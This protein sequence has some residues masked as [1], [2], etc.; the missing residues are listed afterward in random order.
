[1]NTDITTTILKIYDYLG[2]VA[3]A[4]YYVSNDLDELQ[5]SKLD[6]EQLSRIDRILHTIRLQ[7]ETITKM[8][9]RF[10]E[11]EDIIF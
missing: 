5:N 11:L 2:F 1:M 8:Q 9:K 3:A 4:A 6:I 10:E 7:A